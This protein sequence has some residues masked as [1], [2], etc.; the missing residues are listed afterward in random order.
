MESRRRLLWF[1]ATMS[2]LLFINCTEEWTSVGCGNLLSWCTHGYITG[3][4]THTQLVNFS[5]TL[6]ITLSN[7][8][9]LHTSH[10]SCPSFTQLN[11]CVSVL[12]FHECKMA[13]SKIDCG[14]DL[15]MRFGTYPTVHFVSNM[16][17][18][19]ELL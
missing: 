16:L 9:I 14:F 2:S 4:I 18:V 8:D 6:L 15:L 12:S 13:H 1:Q 10:L 19:V 17:Y 5:V 3:Y 7:W 11:L